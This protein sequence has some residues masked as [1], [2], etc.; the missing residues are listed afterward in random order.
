MI[1]FQKSSINSSELYKEVVLL[2]VVAFCLYIIFFFKEYLLFVGF[3][4]TQHELSRKVLEKMYKQTSVFFKKVSIADTISIIMNDV[5]KYIASFHSYGLLCFVEG[6]IYN[7]YLTAI[8]YRKTGLKFTIL[9]ISPF[10]IQ[11]I[12][13]VFSRKNKVKIM[14]K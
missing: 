10:I 4:N 14:R 6:F 9:L 7:G 12:I 11:T 1:E 3:Y 5:N 8:I 2:F 13:F